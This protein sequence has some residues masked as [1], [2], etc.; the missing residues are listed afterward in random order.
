MGELQVLVATMNQRDLSFASTLNAK[1]DMVIANQ[2]DSYS[3]KE[4]SLD[5]WSVTMITTSTHGVGINRNI[6]LFAADAEIVLFADDDIVYYDGLRNGVLSAFRQ[7]P[8][9]DAIVFGI[10]Y[11]KNGIVYR[12]RRLTNGRLHLWNSMRYGTSVLAVKRR[13]IEKL[14]ITFN[15]CFGGGCIYGSGEDNL[16]IKECF[17]KGLR[18]YTSSYVLGV[19]KKDTS[20]W[21]HGCNEKYYYDRG[22]LMVY[23]FP[24]CSR[25]MA[26]YFAVR[27]KRETDISILKRIKLMQQG[28]IGGRSLIPY[29]SSEDSI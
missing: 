6:A 24:C 27:N 5:G 19:C 18:I 15:H 2:A 21:F 13:Q 9:A 12:R 1:C 20:T 10:D 23:L 28:V 14:N 7:M 22:A 26:F 8:E 17:D 25:L 29:K 16:F 4:E 11:S 3:I